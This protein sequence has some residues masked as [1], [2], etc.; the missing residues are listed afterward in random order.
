MRHNR[1]KSQFSKAGFNLLLWFALLCAS[2]DQVIAQAS[3]TA[4]NSYE[5]KEA[6]EVKEESEP[7][8]L[9]SAS[10]DDF[11]ILHTNNIFDPNRKVIARKIR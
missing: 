11:R 9:V 5:T 7:T 10:L 1:N 3:E 2:L 8:K 6:P 4:D